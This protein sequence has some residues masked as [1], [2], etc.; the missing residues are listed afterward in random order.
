MASLRVNSIL[1][2]FRGTSTALITVQEAME[3]NPFYMNAPLHS[4]DLIPMPSVAADHRSGRGWGG[5]VSAVLLRELRS[6]LVNR[7]LQ[8]FSVLAVAAGLA[9]I[10]FSETANAP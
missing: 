3:K 4:V 6:A 9:G 1:P 5:A 10:A 8:V 2:I 7:Y